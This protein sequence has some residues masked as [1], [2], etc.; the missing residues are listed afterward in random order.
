MAAMTAREFNQSTGVAK[1]IAKEEPVFVTERGTI[2][3]V[4]LNIDD[5][6][7]IKGPKRTLADMLSMSD[8]DYFEYDLEQPDRKEWGIAREVDF[9]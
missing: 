3:Y 7:A 2:R 9:S 4:L 8:E 6:N 1:R 5:Y